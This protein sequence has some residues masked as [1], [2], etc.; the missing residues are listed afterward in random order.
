VKQNELQNQYKREC[1]EL[2]KK[3]ESRACSFLSIFPLPPLHS[4]ICSLYSFYPIVNIAGS[5]SCHIPLA[6]WGG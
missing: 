4:P 3:V 5:E 2:E 1:L 6:S